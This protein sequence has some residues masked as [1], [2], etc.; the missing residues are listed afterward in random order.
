M[1]GAGASGV[2]MIADR[3]RRSGAAAVGRR[4]GRAGIC[5]WRMPARI[6]VRRAAPIRFVEQ[7][8]AM[9]DDYDYRSTFDFSQSDLQA[10]ER[11]VAIL[12]EKFA[13]LDDYDETELP[14]ARPFYP[15]DE[16]FIQKALEVIKRERAGFRERR[17]LWTSTRSA[18]TC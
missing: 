17:R 10:I 5:T 7:E 1:A 8:P 2:A 3:R 15:R 16:V 11:A 13:I 18:A 12:E 4:A 6:G 9:N 14:K